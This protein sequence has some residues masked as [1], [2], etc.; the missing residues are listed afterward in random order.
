MGVLAGTDDRSLTV[1]EGRRRAAD[2]GFTIAVVGAVGFGLFSMLTY[3]ASGPAG[4]GVLPRRCGSAS[5]RLRRVAILVVVAS[6][7]WV[8]VGVWIGFN[9][10]VARFMQPVVQLLA[11]FP[12]NFLFPFFL[13]FIDLGISLNFG[14]ILLMALGAQWYI[15]FNVIAGAS[16]DPLGPAR[17]DGQPRRARLAAVEAAHPARHLPRLRHRGDHRL[18]RRLERV[19]RR[20]DRH[21]PRTVINAHGLGAFIARGHSAGDLP[22]DLRGILVMCLYVVGVNT[23]LWRRLYRLAETRYS[24]G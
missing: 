23:L 9:P 18:G 20:R 10:Q 13:V 1:H 7:I 5:S 3:I 15:L 17:G 6:L 2:V 19:D 14:G 21:V 11:S 24:L 12:A 4:L 22:R 16:A 8:P